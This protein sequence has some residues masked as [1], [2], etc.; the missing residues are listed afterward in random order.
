MDENG[1]SDS[2]DVFLGLGGIRV[3]CNAGKWI[4]QLKKCCGEGGRG[5]D[6]QGRIG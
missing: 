3:A 1:V 5:V 2:Q 6:T 4:F